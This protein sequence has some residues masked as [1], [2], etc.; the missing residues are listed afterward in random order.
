[1]YS[2]AW[3]DMFATSLPA[4]ALERELGAIETFAPP[5]SHPRALDIG[6]GVGRTCHG[7][8]A[9]GYRVTGIDVNAEALAVAQQRVPG[10]RFLRLDQRRVAELAGPFDLVLILWHSLGFGS[11]ADD[12]ATIDGIAHVMRPGGVFL[13]DLFHPEWLANNQ[14]AG[15]RDAR[16][17]TIDRHLH[18][19]RCVHR[20]AYPTGAVDHIEFNVYA[21]ADIAARLEVAGFE[22]ATPIAR[23]QT[24]LAASRE[25]AR[26]QLACR[27]R[28]PASGAV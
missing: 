7:L 24:S 1:M 11:R 26:F 15:H 3:F 21:P 19:G 25:H 23:W 2:M 8:A 6:C 17:A 16:G 13:L 27:R 9:R 5:K 10:A 12:E 20:I 28:G 22:V 14:Q 18:S 4:D